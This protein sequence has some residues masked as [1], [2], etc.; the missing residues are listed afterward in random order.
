M[1]RR[2][3]SFIV[4]ALF[5][6]LFN[7]DVLAEKKSRSKRGASHAGAKKESRGNASH[8]KDSHSR[9][10]RGKNS[11]GKESRGKESRGRYARSSRNEK[12]SSRRDRRELARNQ[13]SVREKIIVRGRHGRRLVRYRYVNRPEP[14]AIAAAPRPA[15]PRQSGSGIPSERVMEIQT[16]L[17]KAGYLEG[18]ASGSYDENTIQAMKQFQ[19][20][21]RLSQTGM[22][23]ASTLKKLGVSKRS[24]DGYATPVNS[25]SES[26]KKRPSPAP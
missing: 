12:M 15:A 5:A 18:P 16:A 22:P 10:S 26:D 7:M 21:N 4:A 20:S 2:L 6:G 13:G 14:D 9:E 8:G 11:R 24:N 23:S 1:Q 25:V 19:G 17:I 3:I